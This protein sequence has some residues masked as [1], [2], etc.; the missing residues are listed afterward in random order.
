MWSDIELI[1]PP[2]SNVVS[3]SE[4]KAH[5]R[6]DHSFDDALIGSLIEVATAAIE[7]P[8]GYGVAMLPQTW[9]FNTNHSTVFIPLTP[10]QSIVSV[11]DDDEEAMDYTLEGQT[12]TIEG[13]GPTPY[14]VT[15]VAG[16]SSAPV[17]LKFAVLLMVAHLYH[18]RE[19]ASGAE[20][21]GF[22]SLINKHRVSRFG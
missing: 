2:V 10:V 4:A 12:L 22:L 21:P 3:V 19:G 17:L 13:S 16:Y 20:P 6:V 1:T 8:H 15:F 9:R 18:D 7:G 5:L 11:L 14:V